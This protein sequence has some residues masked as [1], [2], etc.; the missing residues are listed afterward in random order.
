[1][2]LPPLSDPAALALDT[3]QRYCE[4]DMLLRVIQTNYFEFRPL[5]LY[6]SPLT[7]QQIEMMS[8][9]ASLVLQLAQMSKKSTK[10][11]KEGGEEGV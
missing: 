5:D 8:S 4:G 1:M 3:R 11:A 2:Q 10:G 9:D 6:A 7:R